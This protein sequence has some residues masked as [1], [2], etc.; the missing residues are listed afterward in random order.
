MVLTGL[1]IFL[2][3]LSKYLASTSLAFQQPLEVMP[4]F[5]LMLTHNYG[6]AFSFLNDAGGWQRWLFTVIAAGVSVLLVTM[7]Q[8]F[9][10][11]ERYTKWGLALILGGAVGNLLD[12]VIYGH[13]IDFIQWFYHGEH[14]L[15]GFSKYGPDCI[16]PSFNIADAAIFIGAVLYIYDSILVQPKLRKANG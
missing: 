2:D 16:W 9:P 6:A 15:I 8:R 7:L 1:V 14:C 12:R 10:A 4:Y 5:N 11:Q 13:V 3:Q